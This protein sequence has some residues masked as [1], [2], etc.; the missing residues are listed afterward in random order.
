MENDAKDEAKHEIPQHI[1]NNNLGNLKRLGVVHKFTARD[2][3]NVCISI[4]KHAY[5]RRVKAV[6]YL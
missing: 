6:V 4:C 1:A 5:I 2:R 3:S